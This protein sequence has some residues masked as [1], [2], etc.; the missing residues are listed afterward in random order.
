MP[1][2]HRSPE[3]VVWFFAVALTAGLITRPVA[4]LDT[5]TPNTGKSKPSADIPRATAEQ[6]KEDD[7]PISA[8]SE[9]YESNRLGNSDFVVG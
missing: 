8:R 4:T 9:T 5:S 3:L 6:R 1:L 7:P 2:H